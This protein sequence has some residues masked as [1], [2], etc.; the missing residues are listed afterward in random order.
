[1]PAPEATVVVPTYSR[2]AGLARLLVALR[3]QVDA[4]GRWNVVVVNNS[5]SSDAQAVCGL[6]AFASLDLRV[7]DETTAGA[8]AARNRGIEE[9]DGR[10]VAFLD[11]DVVPDERWLGTIVRRVTDDVAG[12]GG[13]VVLDPT[14]AIP[15]WIGD[16]LRSYL[17]AHDLGDRQPR[18]LRDSEFVLSANAAFRREV[19]IEVGGF[20]TRLGPRPGGALFNDDVDLVARVRAAGEVWWEPGACVV[21]DV[22]AERLKPGYLLRRQFA[23]GRSDALTA[24]EQ[25]MERSARKATVR[26]VRTAWPSVK[27]NPLRPGS[28]FAIAGEAARLAG[29]L[30]ELRRR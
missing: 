24:D 18:P 16:G 20:D 9:S 28:A 14:V 6:P 19:L 29:H 17:A 7:V 3:G 27:R 10:V 13:P 15:R 5:P 12:A 2:P 23:Q 1:M 21:H 26:A 11:D 8:G 30:S 22:P 4:P 25:S